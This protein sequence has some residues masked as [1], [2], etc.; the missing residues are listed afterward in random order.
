MND[1]SPRTSDALVSGTRCSI[2]PQS[3]LSAIAAPPESMYNDPEVNQTSW[4]LIMDND[5]YTSITLGSGHVCRR[6][7]SSLVEAS[8]CVQVERNK[9][10]VLPARV[11]HFDMDPP[12]PLKES[13][14]K[15]W[16]LEKHSIAS[17]A[18]YQ[19]GDERITKVAKACSSC[20]AWRTFLHL[21]TDL[22]RCG[23]SPAFGV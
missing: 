21:S 9:R 19:F 4:G 7:A 6:S 23:Y 11:L 8:P 5:Q 12:V 16:V 14:N 15:Y 1:Y 22:L 2:P 18:T 3:P 10:T 20:R 17:M 13:P